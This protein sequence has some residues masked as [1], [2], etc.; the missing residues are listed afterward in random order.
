MQQITHRVPRRHTLPAM[1]D[2]L[3]VQP[4]PTRT[5]LITQA[6]RPP[7]GPRAFTASARPLIPGITRRPWHTHTV[8]SSWSLA[9]A[10]GVQSPG[11]HTC[12][13]Q[14]V[15]STPAR[16]RAMQVRDRQ[17]NLKGRFNLSPI[18]SSTQVLHATQ[19]DIQHAHAT[20]PPARACSWGLRILL[21]PPGLPSGR[22]PGST[23]RL[24]RPRAPP[25]A[26]SAAARQGG[27]L[28][29]GGEHRARALGRQVHRLEQVA[30]LVQLHPVQLRRLRRAPRCRQAPGFARAPRALTMYSCTSCSNG[31]SV[32]G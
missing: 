19:P 15:P 6:A 8:L 16:R 23:L 13:A 1:P 2:V 20:A 11:K 25:A 18:Q 5:S 10:H 4:V 29:D 24:A 3:N 7:P 21:C 17:T 12:R 26:Q 28:A 14:S 22:S 9:G 31:T 27:A 30:D 32:I